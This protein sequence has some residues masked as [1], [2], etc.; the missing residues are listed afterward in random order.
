VPSGSHAGC[1]A[2]A[3]VRALQAVRGWSKFSD[4]ERAL[5]MVD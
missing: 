3:M 1:D 2:R 4:L 5:G